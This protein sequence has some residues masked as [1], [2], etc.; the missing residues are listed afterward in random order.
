MLG[1]ILAWS[2]WPALESIATILIAFYAVRQFTGSRAIGEAQ[3]RAY[4]SCDGGQ[5]SFAPLNDNENLFLLSATI[6]NHGQSPAMEVK[7]TAFVGAFSPAQIEPKGGQV[8]LLGSIAAGSDGYASWS[9]TPDL[10]EPPVR[11]LIFDKGYPLTMAAE[12][13]WNDVFGR[14]HVSLIEL[15]EGGF[16]PEPPKKR[17]QFVGNMHGSTHMGTRTAAPPSWTQF[18]NWKA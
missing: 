8:V 12:L 14:T 7:V 13:S 4:L 11:D 16:P 2:A 3:V 1:A 18:R 10:L 15:S 17:G 5:F 6:K 9:F